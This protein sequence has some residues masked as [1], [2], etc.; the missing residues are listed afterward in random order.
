MEFPV[1]IK[2]NVVYFSAR[3]DAATG[4]G[5]LLVIDPEAMFTKVGLIIPLSYRSLSMIDEIENHGNNC[6]LEG[7]GCVVINSEGQAHHVMPVKN[8]DWKEGGIASRLNLVKMRVPLGP[9]TTFVYGTDQQVHAPQLLA[10]MNARISVTDAYEALAELQNFTS[11]YL[12]Q[13]PISYVVSRLKELGYTGSIV[14]G[15]F[16][17]FIQD[18]DAAQALE[19]KLHE[20]ITNA[21]KD[22]SKK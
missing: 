8:M 2:D 18:M 13:F 11:P 4:G 19:S 20:K 9:H 14:G 6:R 12:V 5:G 7:V 21:S 22:V 3:F 17:K 16:D 10:A 1:T 15:R